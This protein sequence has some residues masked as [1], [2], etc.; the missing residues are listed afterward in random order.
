MRS[1][2]C[3]L[4]LMWLCINLACPIHLFNIHCVFFVS[5]TFVALVTL[6]LYLHSSTLLASVTTSQPTGHAEPNSPMDVL[7][8]LP[9]WV[10]SSQ[11]SL[12]PSTHKM[13]LPQTP[14]MPSSKPIH[15]GGPS[16]LSSAVSSKHGSTSRSL[17]ESPSWEVT[18]QPLTTLSFGQRMTRHARQCVSRNSRMDVLL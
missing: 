13:L 12:E 4:Q 7:P 10:G 18:N 16:G 6:H 17:M 9:P 8:C 11:R 1:S 3:L 15:N 2:G 5:F 14:S